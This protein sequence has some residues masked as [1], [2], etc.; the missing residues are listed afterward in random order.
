MSDTDAETEIDADALA[1][2]VAAGERVSVLDVRDRDEFDAWRVEGAGVEAVQVPYIDLVQARVRDEVPDLVAETGLSEPVVAVCARGEASAEVAS[3]LRENGVDAVNLASGMEGWARVLVDAEI[4][5]GSATVRQY[6]R[7]STG[8]LSYLVVGDAEAAVIDPLR[9]FAGRYAADAAEMGAELRYAVDTH[10]HA[11]HLSGVRAV[12][13]RT[14]AAPV[15]PEGAT[16]R[17]LDF[18]A[19]TLADGDEL[20]SGSAALAAI[21]APGHTSEMTVLRLDDLLFTG[22]SLFLRS[23]ARPDLE[24]GDEGAERAARRLHRTLHERILALPDDTRVAPAHVA[25]GAEPNDDGTY[26]AT[27]G[28]LRERLDVLS[29]PEDEFVETILADVPPRP[30]NYE[31]IIGINLGRAEADDDQA[32][33]LELGPN[34]CAVS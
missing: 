7:P 24:E 28:D 19:R 1:A 26:L 13:E 2:R 3:I 12:A 27:L 29:L 16:D 20:R 4:P 33:E 6:L 17:G 14:G 5:H 18:E 8:C 15:V 10:V 30:A 23:V 9:A 22:D 21:H 34:N 31:E 25:P 11:D 32:F